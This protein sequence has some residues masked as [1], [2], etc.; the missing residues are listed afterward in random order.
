[1]R[2]MTGFGRGTAEQGTTRA[3]VD[4]RA[5]NHRYLDLKL[6]GP[7]SPANEEAISSR[8][9]GA[10]ERGSVSVT[11][12]VTS[13]TASSTRIDTAAAQ[14]AYKNL[15]ELARTLGVEGPNL[16]LVLAQPGVVLQVDEES[17]EA[18]A[19]I[20][21]AVDAAL[22]QLVAMRNAE[23]KALAAELTARI[24]EI[25]QLRAHIHQHAH[26]VPTRTR[27]KLQERLKRLL[28]DEVTD[29]S[30]D[31][32]GWLDPQ[33]LA[34]EVA[35]IAE[36]ADITEELVRLDSHLDQAR[37]LI[38]GTAA[39]G[40]RLEFLIQEIGR[41]LNTIGSKSAVTEISTA[42]VEGKAVL[43]KVREQVQNVE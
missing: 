40:R 38:T 11:V 25:Q 34:Q 29:K 28:A 14:A 37:A 24:N 39:S 8:V 18:D 7:L 35:L 2:S 30:S 26:D 17:S 21:A 9:R 42:I 32:A 16:A 19:P 5:V 43:E 22:A 36:R 1:M 6:R 12:H 31:A 3:T 33:R 41:E 10:I 15:S 4:I 20:L 27:K 13:T 23:G